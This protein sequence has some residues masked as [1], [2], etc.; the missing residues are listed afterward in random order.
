MK[1]RDDVTIKLEPL[2][3][4]IVTQYEDGDVGIHN[5]GWA[6]QMPKELAQELVCDLMATV[7]PGEIK[8]AAG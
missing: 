6:V 4:I 8:E 5:M 7:Y 3:K 2:D 1:R